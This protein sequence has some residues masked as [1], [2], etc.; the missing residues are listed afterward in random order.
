MKDFYSFVMLGQYGRLGN[1]MFQVAAVSHLAKT[2]NAN[3][4]LP[5]SDVASVRR[6]FD[7]PC[8]DLNDSHLQNL[9][10]RWEEPHFSFSSQIEQLPP[11]T[12]ILG[13]LQDWRYFDE[14]HVRSMYRFKSETIEKSKG[15][16]PEGELIAVHVRR[17][18]YLKFPEV[19]PLPTQ[20][21]YRNAIST[22]MKERPESNVV[23]F[24]D[25]HSWCRENFK[26][27]TIMCNDEEIDM[28]M[29]TLCKHHVISNSSFSLWTSWLAKS[30]GQIVYAPKIWFGERGPQDSQNLVPSWYRR[31]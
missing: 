3:L 17:G 9:Q 19:F 12:D 10:R 7:I 1:Q 16:L 6:Y 26:E 13:Y 30:E 28:C 24:T 4:V 23:L 14:N 21:Y 18:D 22:I 11:M 5:K 25:D 27:A 15:L 31:L 2:K 8:V 29:M 20:E